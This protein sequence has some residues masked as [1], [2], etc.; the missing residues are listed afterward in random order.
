MAGLRVK[1]K[2]TVAV[3]CWTRHG[4]W[5]RQGLTMVP[6][7]RSDFAQVPPT[8]RQGNGSPSQAP[9]QLSSIVC[10]RRQCTALCSRYSQSMAKHIRDR[11]GS[12]HKRP[13]C[14]A[15]VLHSS[16]GA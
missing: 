15:A 4:V 7:H 16:V 3:M 1:V 13:Q 11:D 12:S 2:A 9:A 10:A 14:L 5:V 6:D 8:S